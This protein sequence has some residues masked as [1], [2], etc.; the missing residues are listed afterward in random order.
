MSTW[1]ATVAE[2][3]E[4]EG[5]PLLRK[6]NKSFYKSRYPLRKG[7]RTRTLNPFSRCRIRWTFGRSSLWIRQSYRGK[8]LVVQDFLT[9]QVGGVT[10]EC[11]AL[12]TDRHMEGIQAIST[13]LSDMWLQLSLAGSWD[14]TAEGCSGMPMQLPIL[15]L[16]SSETSTE[17]PTLGSGMSA[18]W[19]EEEDNKMEPRQRSPY[20]FWVMSSSNSDS[21]Y[22][23]YYCVL[24]L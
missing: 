18:S 20:Q 23:I 2:G 15:K 21:E 14:S 16:S 3:V 24:T 9:K 10:R 17:T 7:Q 22:Y 13:T 19:G 8:Q 6:G 1:L 12:N 4:E 11:M 5:T